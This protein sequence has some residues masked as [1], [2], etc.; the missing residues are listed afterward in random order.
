MH[1]HASVTDRLSKGLGVNT[2]R[3]DPRDGA[4][5][6][7]WNTFTCLLQDFQFSPVP[8]RLDWAIDV[9]DNFSVSSARKFLDNLTLNNGGHSTHWN[10][11]VPIKI[12]ILI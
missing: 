8:D 9:S 6:E 2:L 5:Q 3:R 10:N 4:E 11:W 7:Q 12:N 1:R